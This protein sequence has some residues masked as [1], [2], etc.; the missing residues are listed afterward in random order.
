MGCA[1]PPGL[2]KQRRSH[3]GRKAKP[4]PPRGHSIT[5]RPRPRRRRVVRTCMSNH[6]G[7]LASHRFEY[8]ID[9]QNLL[10]ASAPPVGDAAGAE[11]ALAVKG[12]NLGI[13]HTILER[14]SHELRRP[15]CRCGNIL[16]SLKKIAD[17]KKKKRKGHLSSILVHGELAIEGALL[18]YK[19][20][21]PA[22]LYY[23]QMRSSAR[24]RSR[25]A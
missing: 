1:S 13:A 2:R 20:P 6:L 4:R 23:I 10:A 24:S 18:S 19:A 7:W 3:A 22:I 15:R 11:D 17:E 25:Y 9:G 21:P 8:L 16:Y 14:D 5:H 12:N